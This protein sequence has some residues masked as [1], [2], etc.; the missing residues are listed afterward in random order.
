MRYA[1]GYRRG[2]VSGG[3]PAGKS[4]GGGIGEKLF[5]ALGLLAAGAV[6]ALS[7]R[8]AWDARTAERAKR[9]ETADPGMYRDVVAVMSSAAETAVGIGTDGDEALPADGFDTNP[10]ESVYDEIGAFFA[11]LLTG[12]A[13][14]R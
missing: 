4:T 9:V 8:G 12:D 13:W 3:R 1:S 2:S 6:L 7:V 10:P 14:G 11:R 5:F